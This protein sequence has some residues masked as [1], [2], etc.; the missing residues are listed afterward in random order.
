[1]VQSV[2]HSTL[3]AGVEPVLAGVIEMVS[4]PSVFLSIDAV[5]E[6]VKVNACNPPCP[7]GIEIDTG[8]L[9]GVQGDA[10]SAHAVIV[11]SAATQVNAVAGCSTT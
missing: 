1:M 7:S 4:V 11:T 6:P 5:V 2:E 8:S 10:L 3:F 9:N